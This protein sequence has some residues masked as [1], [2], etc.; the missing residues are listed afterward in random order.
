MWWEYLY[1]FVFSLSAIYC[2]IWLQCWSQFRM[3]LT[4]DSSSKTV[5]LR[6]G[7]A[8]QFVYNSLSEWVF[9]SLIYLICKNLIGN[10]QHGCHFDFGRSSHSLKKFWLSSPFIWWWYPCQ[11][12]VPLLQNKLVSQF[13]SLSK[14]LLSLIDLVIP[15][16]FVNSFCCVLY[17]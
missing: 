8:C 11:L 17:I 2:K 16:L 13:E 14:V 15:L 10:F 5:E 6:F 9:T 1:K 12:V 4:I 7:F 3:H